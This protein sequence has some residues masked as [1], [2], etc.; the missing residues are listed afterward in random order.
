MYFLLIIFN[1]C[2]LYVY[3]NKSIFKFVVIWYKYRYFI[4]VKIEKCVREFNKLYF[5]PFST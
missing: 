5:S 1:N 2:D 3:S 4:E